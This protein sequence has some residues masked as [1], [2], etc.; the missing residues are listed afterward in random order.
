V[1]GS[2]IWFVVAPGL[3]AG[4]VPW[5]ITGWV[6]WHVNAWW[7][8][9]RILGVVLTTGGVAAL[10]FSF[11]RFLIEG[12]GTPAPV[13]P[14]QRLVVAGLYRCVRNPMYVAVMAV[15]VGQAL[16]LARADLVAYAAVVAMVTTALVLAY[17]EPELHRRF[18]QD[19]ADYQ[20]SVGR[21]CPRLRRRR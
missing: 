19:Y 6:S 12:R 2:A 8:P 16:V 1:I 5:L 20:R 10:V 11:N 14:P 9:M 17:E 4:F 3:I 18:G 7:F 15:I 13:A 21:W